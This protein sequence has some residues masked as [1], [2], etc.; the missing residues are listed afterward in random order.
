[1]DSEA[2]VYRAPVQIAV[3]AGSHGQA[4]AQLAVRAA[5]SPSGR[6]LDEVRGEKM[7]IAVSLDTAAFW[8]KSN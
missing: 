2:E 7:L 3:R 6:R 1:M 5:P 8:D 4:A